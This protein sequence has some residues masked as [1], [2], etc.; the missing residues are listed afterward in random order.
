MADSAIW[1]KV[2]PTTPAPSLDPIPCVGTGG[3]VT[4]D[5]EDTVHTFTADGTFEV[6]EEGWAEVMVCGG[7]GS[8][9]STNMP[10]GGAVQFGWQ[11]LA[12]G[13]YA[14]VVGDG[15]L[16]Q[17]GGGLQ[18][19]GQ[20]SF[21]TIYKVGGGV[22]AYSGQL[23]SIWGRLFGGFYGSANAGAGAGGDGSGATPGPGVTWHGVEYGKGG[24]SGVAA[25]LP[26][27]GGGTTSAP[28]S[29]GRVV[30]RY[31]TAV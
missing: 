3:T 4:T 9:D 13:T 26:G 30:V 6:T 20:S 31:K 7:G 22:S 15:G 25:T 18:H 10:G 24:A 29:A 5:G 19:G 21:G 1:V 2:Y 14:V 23:N 11:R 17:Q 28:G 16:Y 12:V 8:R 27:Q